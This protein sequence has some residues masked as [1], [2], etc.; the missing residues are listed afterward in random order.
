[1]DAAGVDAAVIDG[2]PHWTE[3]AA[4]AF[5]T[6]FASVVH[7]VLP[8]VPHELSGSVEAGAFDAEAPDLDERV[9]AL[10]SRPGRL[11]LRV[12][13][14]HPQSG[15]NVA[16]LEAGRFDR[17]W[18][19]CEKH[20]VPVMIFVWGNPR[21][22]AAIARAFP[23][24]TLI[25]DHL[26]ITQPP[27]KPADSPPFEALPLVLGLSR[28]PNVSVKLIG[29]PTLSASGYPFG[30]VW[31]HLLRMVEAFGPERLMWGSDI[32]AV[33]RHAAWTSQLIVRDA[34]GADYT[35]GEALA[36]IRDTDRLS[37]SD[38]ELI[39]GATLRRVLNWP[40]SVAG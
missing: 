32:Q 10:R 16:E 20:G 14:T 31:P 13:L 8:D 40:R 36:F 11:G 23:D 5:P 22:A 15:E 38:K 29:A 27:W 39:L 2:P 17:L 34:P 1:M 12:P 7:A 28:Y 6:R 9:G 4:T 33:R 21:L 3:Q 30:D 25:V 37:Q 18:R 26:G 24:L 35:Y 19:A